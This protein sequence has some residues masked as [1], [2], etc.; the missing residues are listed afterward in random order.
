MDQG[1]RLGAHNYVSVVALAPDG[2]RPDCSFAVVRREGD[3]PR[4]LLQLWEPRPPQRV[5]DTLREEFLQ[6]FSQAEPM[7]P[8]RCHLGFDEDK[9]WFLQELGG[10][11]LPR[12]WGE[13]D[14][15]GREALRA[16]LLEELAGSRVPRLMWPEV[17]G[18][19]P[20]RILAPRILGVAI[21]DLPSRVHMLDELTVAGNGLGPRPWDDPPDLADACTGPVRGRAL[22]LTYLKS[23]ML[24]LLA[25]IPMERIVLLLGE[26]GLGHERL[27]DWAAAAAE[28]EGIWVSSLLASSKDTTGTFLERLLQ[29]LITGLEPDLYAAMPAVARV[30]SRRMATFAFLREGR[31]SDY[32]DQKVEPSEMEAAQEAIAFALSWHP[33]LILV[34][35]LERAS[36]EVQDLLKELVLTT[37]VPWVLSSRGAGQKS[38]TNALKNHTEAAT[39]VLDRLEDAHIAEVLGDLLG[40]NDL[41][42]ALI[43][44][45]CT[46]CLGNPGLIQNFLE[47]AQVK[48]SLTRKAGRWTHPRGLPP[49]VEMQEDLVAGILAGRLLRVNP[50]ALALVRY[51]ALADTALGLGPLGSAL[52]LNAD[53]VEEALDAAI[54]AKLAL[55]IDGGARLTSSQV[56]DLALA[57][58]APNE[59][60][61]CARVLL[62]VLEKDGSK[63]VLL[64]RLQAFAL[65]PMTALD[66]VLRA[67]DQEFPGPLGAQRIVE[68]ALKLNPTPCQEARLWEFLADNWS[69]ASVGDRLPLDAHGRSPFGFALDALNRSLQAVGKPIC[70][71]EEE[72]VARLQR[73]KG[74]LEMRL[75]RFAEAE[76]SFGAAARLLMDRPFHPERSRLCLAVG[77]HHLFQGQGEKSLLV[78]A[79]GLRLLDQKESMPLQEQVALLLELGRAQGQ[80]ALFQSSLDTLHA[81]QRLLKASG[82]Q[83]PVFRKQTVAVLKALAS[84]RLNLGDALQA[85]LCLQDAMGLARSLEDVELIASC[86]HSQGILDSCRERLG[87]AMAHLDSASHC[88]AILGDPS[89]ATQSQ[90]WKART[91]AALGDSVMAELTLLQASAAPV[92]ALTTLERGD[93]LFL[94]GEIAGFREAW[95]DAARHFQAASNRFEEAG[96]AWRERMARLRCI[97]AQARGPANPVV[98]KSAWVRLE[99]LKG[100]VDASGSR[101]LEVEWQRTHALVLSLS[102][103][104]HVL[105]SETLLVWGEVLAGAR[106][107]P[108]PALVLEASVRASLLLLAAGK[109]PEAQA[110]LREAA[111]AFQELWS[112]VPEAFQKAFLER[113]DIRLFRETAEA[114]GV[115]IA[116]PE[117]RDP[118]ADWNPTQANPSL[119]RSS[120]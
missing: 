22:E 35:S 8:G 119:A 13:T 48:G 33:R 81:A 4:C 115:P 17:I 83:D 56:R 100:P 3:G 46:A 10:T 80:C 85:A 94:E 27:C 52:G 110:C 96:L 28:T 2:T 62:N 88:F 116:L 49:K 44:D 37:R 68:E 65:D 18:L 6:C 20:G 99:S 19:K 106:S 107:L 1:Q 43:A 50:A 71:D 36:P 89:M 104:G 86:H 11:P 91:L 77:R 57:K 113:R 105:Q 29:E 72:Q 40:P 54:S 82:C 92:D 117:R 87:P 90:A 102:G 61:R 79:E 120:E 53:A 101:L 41:P 114:H 93:R 51:L 12:L 67:L 31:R 25:P 9:A 63:P 58:M 42:E 39:V 98:L 97:Q 108:L 21:K 69:K 118:L 32:T 70:G 45:L 75:R 64:V 74:L 103:D 38:C 66:K 16:K 84:V 15:A 95:E 47:L 60:V 14:V 111:P 23:L 7:D 78:L 5:M 24:G 109:E 55:G 34:R 26:I 73:K 112:T 30:L 76:E 59:R